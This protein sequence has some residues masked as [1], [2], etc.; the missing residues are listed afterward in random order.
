MLALTLALTLSFNVSWLQL[1]RS[2]RSMSVSVKPFCTVDLLVLIE[3]I[4]EMTWRDGRSVAEK[5]IV[6]N[7]CGHL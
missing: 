4:I 1:C 6:C 5:G 2:Q 3:S 7:L